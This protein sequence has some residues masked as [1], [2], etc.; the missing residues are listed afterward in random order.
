MVTISTLVLAEVA[1]QPVHLVDVLPRP[2]SARSWS[3]PGAISLAARSTESERRYP[4]WAAP[5]IE[6]GTVSMLW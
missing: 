5:W 3:A 2:T 6:A 4:I 1:E